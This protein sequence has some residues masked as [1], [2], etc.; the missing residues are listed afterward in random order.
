MVQP[1]KYFEKVAYFSTSFYVHPSTTLNAHF[2][3][4]SPANDHHENTHF[5]KTPSKK[6]S[7]KR[8][9]TSPHHARFFRRKKPTQPS[10]PSR[11]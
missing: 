9:N 1:K 4:L 2:T 5:T 11:E 10:P 3:T 7:Q 8:K 6:A